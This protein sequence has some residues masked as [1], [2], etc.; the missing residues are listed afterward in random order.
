MPALKELLT[1]LQER[2][3]L[4]IEIQGHI[5][6]GQNEPADGMDIDTNERALSLNRAK[7][8]YN[9]LVLN[10]IA[11]ERLSYKGF[12]YTQPIINPEITETD[13]T[14]NRRVEI[15]IIKK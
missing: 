12:G 5:C 2:P 3:T 6:C 1:I 14:T 11:E 13:K 8:V 15:K 9:F 10:G 7:A 4:V